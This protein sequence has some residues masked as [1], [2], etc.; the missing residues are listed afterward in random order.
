MRKVILKDSKEN[1]IHVYLY[2][3]KIEII[4]IVH[5]IHGASEHFA[6]YGLFAEFLNEH[7]FL[8]I[9]CDI[10]GHGLSTSTNDYVHFA[11]KKGDLLAFESVELVKDYIETHYPKKDVYILGHSMGS[12]LAR[13]MIILY[14][15]FYKKAIISGTT[16]ASKGLTFFGIALTSIFQC[17]KGP[18]HI[19]KTI[20]NLAIDSNPNKMRKDGL[21]H[22]INEEWLTKDEAIQQYYHA[23]PMCGQP[24]TVSANRNLF[25][26]LNFVNDKKNLMKG[27]MKQPI[28]LISG[29]KDPLSNYGERVVYLYHLMKRLGYESIEYKL[30]NEDRHEILNELDKAVVYQDILEFLE[31]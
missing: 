9:G 12:F 22:G 25:R 24:F 1:Q 17:F 28:L 15:D 2:E 13:K 19:S 29:A 26:W 4:G 11:D 8:V 10:L 31:K 16:H 5:I 6:R 18:R 23:S 7:G 21:I 20:Q 3:P 14:P 30:Y 27:N